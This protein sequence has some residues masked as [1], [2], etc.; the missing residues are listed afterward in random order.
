MGCQSYTSPGTLAR[1]LGMGQIRQ[2]PLTEPERPVF[3]DNLRI[4]PCPPRVEM[5]DTVCAESANGEKRQGP[6]NGDSGAPL[7]VEKGRQSYVL[8]V[9]AAG[10]PEK[11]AC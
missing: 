11:L 4:T 3:T 5:I 9:H 8:A 6:C 1:V 7:L 2:S 10:Y